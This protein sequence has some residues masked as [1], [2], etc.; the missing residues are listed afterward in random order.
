MLA[1][2]SDQKQK[3]Y[4]LA[5]SISIK[6]VGIYYTIVLI[7]IKL[8]GFGS[9]IL[10]QLSFFPKDVES[11]S[12]FVRCSA[13]QVPTDAAVETLIPVSLQG[14]DNPLLQ[15]LLPTLLNPS[16]LGELVSNLRNALFLLFYLMFKFTTLSIQLVFSATCEQPSAFVSLQETFPASPGSRTWSAS[17]RVPFFCPQFKLLLWVC[18]RALMEESTYSITS[19]QVIAVIQTSDIRCFCFVSVSLLVLQHC[20]CL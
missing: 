13:V 12:C 1:I 20:S 18:C 5:K 2:I 8:L 7:K 4:G 9:S 15:Q 16:M 14:K 3:L 6:V 11:V 19:R 17:E 10:Q